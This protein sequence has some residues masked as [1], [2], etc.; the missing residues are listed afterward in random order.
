MKEL[1]ERT[2]MEESKIEMMQDDYNK[3]RS[4]SMVTSQHGV[5]GGKSISMSVAGMADW[6]HEDR[7]ARPSAKSLKI[8]ESDIPSGVVSSRKAHENG[9]TELDFS[10]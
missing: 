9:C 5:D 7:Q 8:S 2:K 10:P 4:F 6:Q 3:N 1:E